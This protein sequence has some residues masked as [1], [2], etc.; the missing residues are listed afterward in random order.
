MFRH[1]A[2]DATH[3]STFFQFEG[4]FVDE[5]VSLADL[6]GVVSA[7][8]PRIVR[9]EVKLR[10]RP[11]YFPFVEPGIEVDMECTARRKT[12]S[13]CSV[14]KGSQWVEIMGAGM[15]HPVVLKNVSIDPARYRG[16]AF[17]GSVDR[18]A[19]LRFGIPDIRLFWSGDPHFLQQF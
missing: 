3:E 9:Q 10:F 8:L 5:D 16:F 4:L 15:I 13:D 1:E 19:I 7:A 14:C 6:K 17:G 18:L 12:H 11:S 2:T